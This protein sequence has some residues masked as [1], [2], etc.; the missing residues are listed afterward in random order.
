[1][2]ESINISLG[3]QSRSIGITLDFDGISSHFKRITFHRE[4]MNPHIDEISPHFE[5]ISLR[6]DGISFHIEGISPQI[7]GISP[8]IHGISLRRRRLILTMGGDSPPQFPPCRDRW[9]VQGR[10][11]GAQ[12]QRRDEGP[13]R[14]YEG[15][16]DP[17]RRFVGDFFLI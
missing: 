4:G 5:R 16:L 11:G 13:P 3:N 10:G 2:R 17:S 14:G 9:G 7:E 8:R 6:I 15:F 1:M 12:R